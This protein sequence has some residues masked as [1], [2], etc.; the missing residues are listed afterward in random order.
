MLIY[1]KRKSIVTNVISLKTVYNAY[2]KLISRQYSLNTRHMKRIFQ[3]NI[4]DI[5]VTY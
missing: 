4:V 5:N 2:Y 1:Y 3:I